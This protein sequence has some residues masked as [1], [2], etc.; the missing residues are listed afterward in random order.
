MCALL[1]AGCDSI[2]G[3]PTSANEAASVTQAPNAGVRQTDSHGRALPFHTTYP[4][5][6][7]SGNDGT[8]YEPCTAAKAPLLESLGLDPSSVEDAAAADFQ[9]A[10]GCGWRVRG[11]R[12]STV[13][14]FVGN[15]PRLV[16]YKVKNSST[17]MWQDD[18]LIAGRTIGIGRDLGSPTCDTYVESGKSLVITS[19]SSYDSSV[20]ITEICD[21]AIAFT[22]ATIDQ[23]PE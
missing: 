3:S 15:Q 22:R 16:E 7:N 18:I 1:L 23:M 4:N 10:R 11:E 17:V 12:S 8:S 13:D 14:Q 19:A 2:K 6:W 21:R 20:P 5:R 9:T